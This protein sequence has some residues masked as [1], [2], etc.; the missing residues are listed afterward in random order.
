MAKQSAEAW[1]AAIRR[2]WDKLFAHIGPSKIICIGYRMWLL[3]RAVIAPPE[4]DSAVNLAIIRHTYG[5]AL[6]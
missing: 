4:V 1:T 2:V 3:L 5:S 6:P